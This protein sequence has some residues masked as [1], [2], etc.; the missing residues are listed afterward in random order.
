MQRFSS[1]LD[2]PD[3]NRVSSGWRIAEIFVRKG[4][5]DDARRQIG[6][7][8]AEARV[9]DAQRPQRVIL[10]KAGN[11][12]CWRCMISISPRHISKKAGLAGASQ[13]DVRPRLGQYLFGPGGHR[14]SAG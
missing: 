3:G 8:F 13:R 7:A 12:L 1:A 14:K 5:W 2:A 9:G 11:I 6:L 4:H 10:S